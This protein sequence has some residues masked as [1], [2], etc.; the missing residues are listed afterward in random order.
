MPYRKP[1]KLKCNKGSERK[2]EWLFFDCETSVVDKKDNEEHQVLRLGVAQYYRLNIQQSA[3]REIVFRTPEEFGK[4]LMG[5]LHGK[6]CL[7]VMSMNIPFDFTVSAIGHYLKTAGWTL[8]KAFWNN[9]VTILKYRKGKQSIQFLDLFNYIKSSIKSIGQFINLPKLDIDFQSASEAELVEY[10]RRDVEIV[11]RMMIRFM[12][13]IRDNDLGSLGVTASQCAFNAFRHRFMRH[14]IF[15]H[16]LQ[17][18]LS[19]ERDSYYGGRVEC[20]YIGR[21]SKRVHILDVNSM[22]SFIMRHY[23]VPIKLWKYRSGY[24]PLDAL[25]QYLDDYCIIAEC[26][27]KTDRPVYP[28]RD[29]NKTLFPIGRYITTL[30]TG[31]LKYALEHGHIETVIRCAIYDKAVI[32]NDYVD[33]FFSLKQQYTAENNDVLARLS[34]LYLNSLYGK[35]GQWS[36]ELTYIG[37][38]PN[39]KTYRLPVYDSDA[40][41]LYDE[42][43]IVGDTFR[44]DSEKV[45]SYNSFTAIASHITDY[46]RMYLYE[47]MSQAGRNNVLYCDTDSIFV[48]EAGFRRLTDH[49]NNDEIG[50]LKL[51]NSVDYIDIRGLKD[52]AYSG[53]ERIK[54]ISKHAVK[55]WDGSYRQVHF[56]SMAGVIQTGLDPKIT[57]KYVTK[58]LNRVYD[59]GIVQPSGRVKPFRLNSK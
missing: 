59:K 12:T 52:Y 30:N 42:I 50:L 7:N 8:K 17:P 53:I 57:L 10:C 15:I 2:T 43:A 51:V 26:K 6:I 38:Q 11:A 22:Y 45:E 27:L 14:D 4:F 1:H 55:L 44:L 9:D 5:C 28:V 39:K 16:N 48:N 58:K 21:Y 47:L 18:A 32:F 46:A 13:F 54:G 19:L 56:P 3:L 23:P 24:M 25:M 37:Y 35:F 49:I 41:L 20:Y 36:R 31:S 34:K 33:Y 29:K 40:A